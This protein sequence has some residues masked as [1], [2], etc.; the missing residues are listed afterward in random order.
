M[1]LVSKSFLIIILI[2]LMFALIELTFGIGFFT[3][4][5]TEKKE[6][7]FYVFEFESNHKTEVSIT[8][9]QNASNIFLGMTADNL[10]FGIIPLGS[11]SKRFLDL[12]NTDEKDYGILLMVTGNISPMVKFDKNDFVLHKNE[13]VKITVSLNSSLAPN[14][15]NYTG[16]ISIISKRPKFSFLNSLMEDSQ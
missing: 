6:K 12:T 16:E 14:L 8:E 13:N 9:Q 4:I 2:M 3:N 5:L 15:G 10:E 7:L 1:G 11:I